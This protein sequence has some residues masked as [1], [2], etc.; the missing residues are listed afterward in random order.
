MKQASTA[1]R[2]YHAEILPSLKRRQAFVRHQLVLFV[3]QRRFNPTAAE[4]LAFVQATNP[5]RFDVNNVRPRLTEL[6][7][8]GWVRHGVKRRCDITKALVMTWIPSMPTPPEQQPLSFDTSVN[9]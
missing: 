9:Q 5:G 7:A 1:I 3:E 6:E 4:L 8:L 2:H